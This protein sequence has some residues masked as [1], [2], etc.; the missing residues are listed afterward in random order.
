[1]PSMIAR[2]FT[3]ISILSSFALGSARGAEPSRD[4]R[5]M[6]FNVRTSTASDGQNGWSHRK[7]LF[8]QTIEAFHPD[9]LGF[10]EVRPDQH[11]DIAARLKDYGLSGVAR[12]D[13]KRKG[14]WSLIAFRKD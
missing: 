13:G 10:Q 12:D 7:D 14:E 2:L 1:M 9:L 3:V 8:F 11:D 4:I 5:V 6:S